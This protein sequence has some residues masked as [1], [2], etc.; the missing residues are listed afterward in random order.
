MTQMHEHI[1][2]DLI[3]ELIDGSLGAEDLGRVREHLE[4]CAVCNAVHKSLLRFDNT[5]RRLPLERPG[6]AFT[7]NVM[8]QLDPG[9]GLVRALR[10]LEIVPNILGL[11]IV[12]GSMLL[13]FVWT[14]VVDVSRFSWEEGYF[15]GVA[16]EAGATIS[17][18]LGTASVW[19]SDFL[20]FVFGSKTLNISISIVAVIVILAGIDRGIGRR[21]VRKM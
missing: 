3:Q 6:P 20:P 5:M 19:L 21:L 16:G 15:G 2:D 17:S 8:A 1:S 18:V 14:G 4:N 12:L 10:F 13:V 9:L 7:A 11:S